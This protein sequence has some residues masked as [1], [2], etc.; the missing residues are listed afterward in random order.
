MSNNDRKVT[1]PQQ[2]KDYKVSSDNC[3]N[4]Q[5]DKVINKEA[6]KDQSKS[7]GKRKGKDKS[8]K[9]FDILNRLTYVLAPEE[10]RAQQS[11]RP[12]KGLRDSQLRG[13]RKL[14]RRSTGCDVLV[15]A[16]KSKAA[17]IRSS[18]VFDRYDKRPILNWEWKGII[19]DFANNGESFKGKTYSCVKGFDKKLWFSL[20]E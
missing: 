14:R 10:M 16:L 17:K 5:C 1:N 12:V 15:R 3:P 18:K 20:W 11:K 9:E 8:L 7:K 19:E 13:H 2:W 4:T 6:M